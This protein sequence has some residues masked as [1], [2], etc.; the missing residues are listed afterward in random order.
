MNFTVNGERYKFW[1]RHE[2]FDLPAVPKSKRGRMSQ[3]PVHEHH[4]KYRGDD[5]PVRA[6]THCIVST[7]PVSTPDPLKPEAPPGE[8]IAQADAYCSMA[9]QYDKELGRVVALKRAA[10]LL[11][12]QIGGALIEAYYTRPRGKRP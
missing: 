3:S 10:A 6:I 7:A 12:R 4:R 11:D 8:V 5:V 2:R 1:F 9:D